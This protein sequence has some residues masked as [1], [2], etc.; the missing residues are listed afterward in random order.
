[1]NTENRRRI[2]ILAAGKLDAFTAKTAA[3][4]IRYRRQEVVGVLDPE[5]AGEPLENLIGVGHGIPIV[6]SLS[7]LDDVRPDMLV[8][9]V[10]TPGGQLPKTWRKV[11]RQAIDRGMEIVNGLHTILGDDPEFSALAAKRGTKIWDVRQ[12][13]EISDVGMARA[14]DSP[15]RIVLTVGSDCNLGKKITAIE[16]TQE[17]ER[18]G[19]NALFLATG[20][21]GVMISGRGVAID[22]VVSDFVSGAVEKLILEESQ[23]KWIIVEG[24]GAIFHPSYSA[25]TLGLM[26][27]ACPR[28]MVLCHQPS[29]H[30]LR[31]TEITIPP[32]N[33]LIGVHESLMRPILPSTVVG[34]SLNCI[35]LSD[36]E[37][38]AVVQETKQEV[39]LP[40]ADVVRTGPAALVD[41]LETHFADHPID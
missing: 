40:V 36:T 1:M 28:A 3:G 34:I 35:D 4:I 32:L 8:I 25:V 17:L 15:A 13:P 14:K 19:E 41:A 16:I 9:G 26:H 2:V 29:R 23:Y 12:A 18:R 38:A 27:G 6:S 31:H 24:Q 33:T 37:Y 30:F 5:H 11:L 20:Q 22:C 7:E 10:A 21:T 39:G